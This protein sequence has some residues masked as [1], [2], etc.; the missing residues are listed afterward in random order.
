MAVSTDGSEA[1]R[2]SPVEFWLQASRLIFR[3][4]SANDEKQPAEDSG[5]MTRRALLL[6]MPAWFQ[7]R[8]QRTIVLM[9]DGL[10]TDYIATSRMPVLAGWQRAGISKTVEGVMPSVTNAN[11]VSICCGVWPEKHGITANFFLDEASG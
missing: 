7:R 11:N 8:Q 9:V 3:Y 4:A 5:L 2:P 1:R 6:S 10:G